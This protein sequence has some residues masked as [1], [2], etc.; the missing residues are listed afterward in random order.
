MDALEIFIIIAII[1]GTWYPIGS[2]VGRRIMKSYIESCLGEGGVLKLITPSSALAEY[3]VE[4]FR[5]LGI[6][7][8]WLPFD[9]PFNLA[10]KLVSRRS[11]IAVIKIEPEKP[12]QGEASITRSELYRG[13]EEIRGYRV[14]YR[15]ISRS[16][17][18][19]IVEK[20]ALKNIDK[21]IIG[22]KPNITIITR[23][24]NRKCAEI[25]RKSMELVEEIREAS[26]H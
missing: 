6:Y 15:A 21:L 13:G 4:R 24:N 2:W 25:L 9:N 22:S 18:E 5:Y 1:L 7:I 23:A 10:V 19:Q 26:G 12:I 17:L 3:R 8:E 16:R 14:V 20:V 11:P